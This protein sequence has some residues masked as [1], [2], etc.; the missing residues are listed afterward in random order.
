MNTVRS[1][2]ATAIPNV[3]TS[4]FSA[5]GTANVPS[6]TAMT[7]TLSSESAFSIRKPAQ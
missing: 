1:I 7:N 4:A 5:C 2:S 6:S 3:N